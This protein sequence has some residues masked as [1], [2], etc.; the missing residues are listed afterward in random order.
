MRRGFTLLLV[1]VKNVDV[2]T[3]FNVN[4]VQNL[5][6][7]IYVKHLPIVLASYQ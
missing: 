6:F 1:I 2:L 4:L 5:V 7:K 3:L